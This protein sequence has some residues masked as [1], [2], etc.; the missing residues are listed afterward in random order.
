MKDIE[1]LKQNLK[2]YT[3]EM[4]KLCHEDYKEWKRDYRNYASGNERRKKIN[5]LFSHIQNIKT[6]INQ[7]NMRNMNH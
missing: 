1:L 7:I 6:N 3:D 4:I 5:E 2:L